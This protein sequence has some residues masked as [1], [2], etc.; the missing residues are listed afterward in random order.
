MFTLALKQSEHILANPD[1]IDPFIAAKYDF[2]RDLNSVVCNLVK[3]N[4]LLESSKSDCI[5][6]YE[7]HCAEDLSPDF[8]L[9]FIDANA[10]IQESVLTDGDVDV[11]MLLGDGMSHSQAGEELGLT[12]EEMDDLVFSIVRKIVPAINGGE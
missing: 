12:R 3:I 5:E 10:A 11:L 2:T 9:K 1:F 7:Q 6:K 8:A 4:T